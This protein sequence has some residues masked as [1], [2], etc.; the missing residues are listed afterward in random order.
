MKTSRRTVA[1]FALITAVS[2]CSGGDSNRLPGYVEGEFV[3]V[4]A[5][6]S[7]KLQT[8]Y[9]HRGAEV[10]QDALLFELEDTPQLASRDAANARFAQ[11]QASVRDARKGQR[12]TEVDALQAQYQQA[13]AAQKFSEVEL[14]RQQKLLSTA[15]GSSQQDVDRARSTRDQANEQVAAL[16]AQLKTARLGARADQV[17]A[18]QANADALQAQLTQAEWEL[19]QTHQSATTA[20]SVA[21]TLYRPGEWIAAGHPVVVLLPP[22]NIKVR[23]YVPEAKLSSLT[24]GS[25]VTVHVDGRDQALNGTIDFISPKIEF[26]PPVIYS[27]AMRSKFVALVE[28]VFDPAVAT[29]LHPGQPVDVV[30]SR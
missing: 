13:M 26:A 18:A 19:A 16:A 29:T 24:L 7:G 14:S 6:V 8:L 12:P 22:I 1:V 2:G 10:A 17:T 11:A 3:Y 5:P 25:A 4:S 30:L 28:V 15:V 9:V 20:G 27:Q 23:M 21:D